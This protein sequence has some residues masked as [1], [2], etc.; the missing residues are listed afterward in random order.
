MPDTLPE[1]RDEEFLKNVHHVLLDV[2]FKYHVVCSFH[3]NNIIYFDRDQIH[4]KEGE[5]ICPHCNRSYPISQ[6]IPNMVSTG[7]IIQ[8]R[9]NGHF[10]WDS[11]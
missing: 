2:C 10:F 4:I 5:M 3:P 1:N 8:A 6:G 9:S 7:C 11:C